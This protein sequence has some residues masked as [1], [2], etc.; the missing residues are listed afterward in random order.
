[1]FTTA[2]PG[3]HEA[4]M[5]SKADSPSKEAPY[6][7]LVGTATIGEEMSPATTDGSAPSI[8][9]TTIT[10]SAAS[11]AARCS[12]I[13][14]R[15][16]PHVGDPFDA[17][18]GRLDG[19]GSFL[20]D[21]Q[22]GCSGSNDGDRR[23][24]R[25]VGGLHDDQPSCFPWKRAGNRLYRGRGLLRRR[26]CEQHRAVRS[27]RQGGCDLADL[28]DRLPGAV[29]R[30]R[31]T[32]AELSVVIDARIRH[33]L[34]RQDPE[35]LDGVLDGGRAGGDVVEQPSQGSFVHE[36]PHRILRKPRRKPQVDG[37][38]RDPRETD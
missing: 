34:V 22:I 23:V 17:G 16:R 3:A 15:L 38:F 19:D 31:V 1:M 36:G 24:H 18:S 20:R 5:V 7:T 10:Q 26:A 27:R 29:D 25:P 28:F 4:S 13:R 21:G 37:R 33:R 2:T 14:G 30:F 9:A 11:S 32:G 12:R 8:P 6:P 35:R